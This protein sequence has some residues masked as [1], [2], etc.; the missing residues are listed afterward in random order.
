MGAIPRNAIKGYSYQQNI[1]ILFLAIMDTERK[2]SKITLEATETKHFDDLYLEDVFDENSERKSY[3]IQVKNYP[4]TTLKDVIVTEN[5]V[6][7]KNN[8]NDYITSDNNILVINS[9]LIETTDT[10]MGIPCARKDNIVIIPITPEQC[11]DQI[12]NMFS[13]EARALQIIHKADD[14]TQN[15][16]FKI[17]IEEL[18]A[19]IPMS[20][21]LENETI[22]LR[23]VPEKFAH[24]ITFIEGKPGVGKSHFVNELCECYSDAIVYRFWIG[25]QDPDVNDRIQFNKFISELGI[26]VYGSAKRVDIDELIGT[27][28]KEDKLIVID[29][30]DHVENYNPSQLNQFVDFIDRLQGIRVVV[31]SRPL[32]KEMQWKKVTLLD[33]TIDETRLYLEMAY[34]I[35]DYRIQSEIFGYT[36][37]YPIITYYVAEDYKLNNKLNISEKSIDSITEYYDTLFVN[38][39]KPSSAIGIFAVGNCFFTWKELESFFS[40]PELFEII[41]EFISMHPYLFKIIANRVSL[42]HDS[43]NTYLRERINTFSKRKSKTLEDIRKSLLNGSIEYMDRMSS[44]SLDSD[45]YIEML[46][47]YSKF[48]EFEKL[49]LSTRDY[50]S[51]ASLYLQL[52]KQLELHKGVL[53]IYQLYAFSLL[54]EI[55]QRNDLIGSDSLVIQML[56]Y[57]NRHED[58]E[59]NIYSSAYIWNVYLACIGKEEMT[60]RYLANKKMSENQYY[61][62]IE[63]INSDFSFY[64]KKS[65]I[66]K[67]SDVE[68]QLQNREDS[69]PDKILSDYFVSIWIHGDSEDKFYDEFIEYISG[70]G[71]CVV[72]IEQELALFK[73]E[74][75]WIEH[76][77]SSAEYQLHEL[78]YFEE[79]NRFRN[80]SLEDV[81]RKG[82]IEGA[83]EVLSLTASYMKLANHE[84]RIIDIEKLAYVW[85]IYYQ[86]K[87]YSVY[88]I[89]DALIIF[90]KENL[91]DE[92]ES[93]EIISR[94]MK[95]SEKGISHLLTNYINQ[96]DELYVKKLIKK[97][98]FSSVNLIRFWELKS[99]FI[100]CF[101]K[102]GMSKQLTELL[103]SHAYSRNIE[104]KDI[105]NAMQSKYKNMVLDGIEYFEYSIMFPT[106]DL[107]AELDSRDIKYILEK[108]GDDNKYIPLNYG[109]IQERDF[110]YIKE[111]KIGYMDVARYTDGW[112]SCLPYIDVFTIFD[113]ADIQRDYLNIIYEAMFAKCCNQTYIGEWHL[114]IGNIIK[115][116]KK[117][118][119]DVDYFKLYYIFIEFLDISLIWHKSL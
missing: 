105:A 111:Q 65:K 57:M 42:I 89:D 20:V 74:R 72:I 55:S 71:E 8:K 119:I 34:N 80:C 91:I 3:R 60:K 67:Y 70:K 90:E 27:I 37:G 69:Y 48:E 30:L 75:F 66:I 79:A 25:S 33:W 15:A 97:G 19:V 51:I 103:E 14:I 86:R 32:K 114:L 95:Q 112:Y 16:K 4:E 9:N 49:M 88:T 94:L 6:S 102:V 7:V 46:K 77:L 52:Q 110:D 118:E 85:T 17:T 116:L 93:F 107:L 5:Y 64:E 58:I 99:S 115:F 61:D 50:N 24:E 82:A 117:F 108:D 87:D 39:D 68:K 44:F 47:K 43:F 81:I 45:F 36:N 73:I 23:K 13:S 92:N 100:D 1:F 26:K 11:A 21:D 28:K 78:G 2:I 109:C 10:F 59:D 38:N 40:D 83:F 63:A 18:P 101:D 29:G 104:F 31:L 41:Q 106:N 84:N 35:C 98:Y 53:D 54:F 62:L 113:K 22:L 76:G 12:D 96:K 56:I